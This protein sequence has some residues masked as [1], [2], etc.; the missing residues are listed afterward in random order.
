MRWCIVF[1]HTAHFSLDFSITYS[2][3]HSTLHFALYPQFLPLGEQRLCNVKCQ[4]FVFLNPF[5]YLRGGL[6]SPFTEGTLRPR[7]RKRG[8]SRGSGAGTRPW[9]W[10]DTRC[11]AAPDPPCHI[12]EA[13]SGLG[14]MASTGLCALNVHTLSSLSFYILITGETSRIKEHYLWTFLV[15]ISPSQLERRSTH[16]LHRVLR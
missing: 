15:D 4:D 16:P 12:Q 14:S 2:P 11:R 10:P 7:K 3:K 9:S 13:S 6:A 8:L 1:C 5:A